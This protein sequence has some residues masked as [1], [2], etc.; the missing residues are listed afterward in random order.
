MK[1]KGVSFIAIDHK[2]SKPLYSMCIFG[3]TNNKLM[4][5][6]FQNGPLLKSILF[7]C[8]G[9]VWLC[10]LPYGVSG[11]HAISIFRIQVGRVSVC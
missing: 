10:V 4:I 1:Y 5:L 2:H 6:G 3:K 7:L 8:L 11:A 9:I